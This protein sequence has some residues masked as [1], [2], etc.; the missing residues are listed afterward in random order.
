M[1]YSSQKA[2][3]AACAPTAAGVV[4]RHRPRMPWSFT[5]SRIITTGPR[6]L[7]S[8]DCSRT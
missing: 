4:P 1:Q 5:T 3:E 6:C 7:F 2:N 8:F